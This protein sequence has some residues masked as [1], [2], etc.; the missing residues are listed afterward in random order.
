M[1][2]WGISKMWLTKRIETDVCVCVWVCVCVFERKISYG[3]I[4]HNFLLAVK[5]TL[6]WRISRFIFAWNIGS[7][8]FLQKQIKIKQLAPVTKTNTDE[9]NPSHFDKKSNP[10]KLYKD[11]FL[12]IPILVLGLVPWMMTS[13]ERWFISFALWSWISSKT[14]CSCYSNSCR[15][16]IVI[17][18][19]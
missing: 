6:L 11:G 10:K 5:C 18:R 9:R 4:F 14:L 8:T 2:W 19:R 15:L 3:L 1:L 16:C 7:K 12:S 13:D 17:G